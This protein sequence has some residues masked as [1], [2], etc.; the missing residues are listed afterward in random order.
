MEAEHYT[1]KYCFTKGRLKSAAVCKPR[2]KSEFS[3]VLGCCRRF[4]F[5]SWGLIAFPAHT[6]QFGNAGLLHGHAVEHAAGFHSLAIVGDDDELCLR[7]HIADQSR[8]TP[9]VGFVQWGVHFV[10]NA[11]WARLVAEDCDQKSQRRHGFFSSG[12]QKNILQ[13]LT[14][15]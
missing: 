11:E 2:K 12:E 4:A 5:L 8:E 15:M 9:D 1:G 6:D 3:L 14:G 7:A 13:A 10:Q